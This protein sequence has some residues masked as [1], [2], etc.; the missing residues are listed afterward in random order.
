MRIATKALV[1]AMAGAQKS[2]VASGAY[3]GPL[4]QPY[5]G[6]YTDFAP[7]PTPDSVLANLTEAAFAGYARQQI[8]AWSGPSYSGGVAAEILGPLLEFTPSDGT[9]PQVILGVFW[10]DAL[11]DG[12]LLGVDPFDDPFA[13]PD[14]F[15]TL[16]WIAKLQL[17][18]TESYGDG[19]VIL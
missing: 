17:Q 16:A 18:I 5:I 11:T 14:Q 10:A 3:S 7:P 9:A 13:L 15:T 4:Y 1:L 12:N 2:H 19:I 6:L 8:T